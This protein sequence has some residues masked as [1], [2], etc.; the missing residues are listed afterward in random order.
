MASRT[1]VWLLL[2]ATLVLAS[3][4]SA[5]AAPAADE[6][7]ATA[8]TDPILVVLP[9]ATKRRAKRSQKKQAAAL[10]ANLTAA[11]AEVELAPTLVDGRK[12]AKEKTRRVQRKKQRRHKAYS[13][14]AKKTGATH[15][16]DLTLSGRGKRSKLKAE[17][18]NAE[19][20][21]V[22]GAATVKV[23]KKGE[24]PFIAELVGALDAHLPKKQPPLP[25]PE[26][27]PEPVAEAPT[28]EDTAVA[29]ATTEP[30]VEEDVELEEDDEGGSVMP[31]VFY[32]SSAFTGLITVGALGAGVALGVLA[33]L[34]SVAYVQS[35]PNAY[36][37]AELR[38]Q[39]EM[40]ALGADALYVGAAVA[41]V[42]TLV[43]VA[44]GTTFLLLE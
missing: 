34:D 38:T 20:F 13:R 29:T 30:E 28:R 24:G 26:P 14:V 31:Y 19:T 1:P 42:V 2:G 4:A 7:A 5:Q 21:E 12:N 3:P 35:A 16:L 40:K 36:G 17:I 22:L 33:Y 44:S 43:L 15:L 37:R 18:I 23:G 32:G 8:G 9:P 10:Q 25:P 41:G 11:L 39:S 6:A 27:E